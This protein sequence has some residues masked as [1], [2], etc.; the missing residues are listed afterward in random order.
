[1]HLSQCPRCNQ[2]IRSHTVCAN[3][4][5]YRD[6]PVIDVEAEQES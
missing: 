6:Q 3:C 2:S 1:M 5:H 4:G